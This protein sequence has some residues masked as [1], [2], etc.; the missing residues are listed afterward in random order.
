[1]LTDYLPLTNASRSVAGLSLPYTLSQKETV[2]TSN[3]FT[4]THLKGN[5]KQGTHE[6]QVYYMLHVT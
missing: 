1:M 3:M 4:W 5:T 2:L 6:P